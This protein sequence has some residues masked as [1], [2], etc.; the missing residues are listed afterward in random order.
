MTLNEKFFGFL[1]HSSR[2][3]YQLRVRQQQSSVNMR[4]CVF[5]AKLF[6]YV[7]V[8][9]TSTNYSKSSPRS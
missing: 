6:F 8:T 9:T 2:R 5:I 4:K 1:W 3:L 7:T